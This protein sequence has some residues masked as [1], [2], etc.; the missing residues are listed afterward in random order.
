MLLVVRL[1]LS[2]FILYADLRLYN[3]DVGLEQA[4]KSTS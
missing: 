4:L 3:L 2:D 1:I